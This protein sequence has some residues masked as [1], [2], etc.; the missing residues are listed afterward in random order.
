MSSPPRPPYGELIEEAR[1]AARLSKREAARR[2]GISDAWWRYVIAGRQGETPVPGSPETVAAMAR[3]VGV[4]PERLETEGQ[5]PDAAE[6][7]RTEP[8]PV[9]R[10]SELPAPDPADESLA[11][12][13]AVLF[14]ADPV[15]QG[16]WR[17]SEPREMRLA[18]IEAVTKYPDDLTKQLIWL[19]P[20][21]E[22][23]KLEI[24]AFIDSKRGEGPPEHGEDG[25]SAAG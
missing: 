13:A 18:R 21:P 17:R 1:A 19:S 12:E 25:A 11:R 20:E 16:I 4:T 22:K 14:P 6:I 2:A 5:R 7:L 3:A 8:S 15:K 10:R 9:P 24:I 23:V